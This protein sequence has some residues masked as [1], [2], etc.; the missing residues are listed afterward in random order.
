MKYPCDYTFKCAKVPNIGSLTVLAARL[1]LDMNS[2]YEPLILCFS[3]NKWSCGT[4]QNCWKEWNAL[5]RQRCYRESTYCKSTDTERHMWDS[6]NCT[7]SAEWQTQIYAHVWTSN[8][9]NTKHFRWI[10]FMSLCIHMLSDGNQ[11]D[12][13]SLERFLIPYQYSRLP[14][15]SFQYSLE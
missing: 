3:C 10:I 2:L 1:H 12:W 11:T 8:F 14:L 6:I 7:I 4:Y 5:I 15:I 9:T 13:N